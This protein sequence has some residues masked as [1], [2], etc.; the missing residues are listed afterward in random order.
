MKKLGRKMIVAARKHAAK[1]LTVGATLAAVS[2]RA[3]DPTDISGVVT[4]LDGYRTAAVAVG[5]AVL[6]FV[7][8]RTI[9]RK[10]AK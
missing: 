3:A 9:V 1:A 6:L 7:L 4:A 8:G 2:A 5:V 10:I